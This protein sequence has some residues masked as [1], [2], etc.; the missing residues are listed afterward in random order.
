MTKEEKNNLIATSKGW[1]NIKERIFLSACMKTPVGYAPGTDG[2]YYS[3]IPDYSGDLNLIHDAIN[4]EL[5]R[6]DQE[7]YH[8]L[9]TVCYENRNLLPCPAGNREIGFSGWIAHATAENL[10][11]AYIAYFKL[12]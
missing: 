8:R 9:E 10:C 2:P 4:D 3:T 6:I 12:S 1:T 11:D 5:D 7:F